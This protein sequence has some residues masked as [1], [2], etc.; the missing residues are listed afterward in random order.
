MFKKVFVTLIISLLIAGLFYCDI[1][2]DMKYSEASEIYQVY[3]DGKIIGYLKDDKELYSLINRKQEEIRKKYNV[4]NVY[5][6]EDLL[7]VK[8]N[9][10]NVNIS[11][12][13]SIYDKMAQ[14]AAFTIEGFIISIKG[15]T[16]DA[17]INVLHPRLLHPPLS[18]RVYSNSCPL[19]QRHPTISSSVVPFSS[20]LQSFPTSESFQMSQLFTS[21]GQSI[22][23][24]AAA[25]VLPINIQD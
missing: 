23:V 25:S 22:G 20:H 10:Y 1:Y 13:E 5:P 24:S 11:S 6:P 2:A 16:T 12:A 4:K 9:K 3:L 14:S 21:G 7:I 17:K 18:P 8:T 15:E 19:S